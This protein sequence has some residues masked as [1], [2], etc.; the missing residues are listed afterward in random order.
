MT[1]TNWDRSHAQTLKRKTFKEQAVAYKGGACALCGYSKCLRALEFHHVTTIKDFN[2]GGRTTWT[3]EVQR[4]LDR[5]VLL[6]NRCHSEV[7]DGYHP[8]YFPQEPEV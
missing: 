1:Y 5:T 3:P 8:I 6:C 7:H 2:V 4:E